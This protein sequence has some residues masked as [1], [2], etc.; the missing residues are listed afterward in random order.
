MVPGTPQA[1]ASTTAVPIQ[2][3]AYVLAG[4][5]GAVYTFGGATDY[6]SLPAMGITPA[7]PVV[8]VASAPTGHGYW[9]DASDGGVFSFGPGAHFYGSMGGRPLAQPVVGMAA[10]PATGGYWLVA[11][12]GGIFSFN[13]PFYGSVPGV[14]RGGPMR[15]PAVGMAAMPTGNG[16]WVVAADGGIF[17]FAARG[18]P[19]KFFGST[20]A[21]TLKEP[22]VGMA[23]MATGN[24]YWLVAS[25]GG[26]FSFGTAASHFYGSL[27]AQSL[28][29]PVVGMSTTFNGSG[30]WIASASG[31]VTNYATAR[32]WGQAPATIAAPVVGIATTV[33]D[34]DPGATTYQSGNYGFDVSQY[35]CGQTLPASHAIGIVEVE[36]WSFGAVNPCLTQQVDWAAG[37]LSLYTFLSYGTSTTLEPGCISNV[38]APDVTACNFGYAAAMDSYDAALAAIGTRVHVPWWFD[39]ETANWT[40]T[41]AANRSLVVGAYD[42]LHYTLGMN[43][44]GFYLGINSWQRIVGHYNPNA[45]LF[46]AWWTGPTPAYKCTHVRTLAASYNAFFPN[47]PIELLQYTDLATGRSLDGDYAC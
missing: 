46:P 37:G 9:M 24:G 7:H 25:D 12:D 42:A 21:M 26:I 40:G 11:S 1:G 5:D 4:S 23:P 43:T 16:Y 32:P 3:N 27:G 28:R 47:G 8:G 18:T 19:D 14:L 13:A 45:P 34:G 33:G 30:Y 29:Y 17:T 41:T 20:G 39:V 44:V 22:I 2:D 15:E 38:T 36:G 10:D 31:A 35:Q 6:G